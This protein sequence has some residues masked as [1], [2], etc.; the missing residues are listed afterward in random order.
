MTIPLFDIIYL[1]TLKSLRLGVFIHLL[2][3]ES[4]MIY[5]VNIKTFINFFLMQVTREIL[6][7]TQSKSQLKTFKFI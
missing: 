3:I 1:K 4:Q 5:E 2:R 7:V 6:Q